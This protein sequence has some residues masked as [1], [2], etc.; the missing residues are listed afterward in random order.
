MK[1]SRRQLLL[2]ASS[3]M[4][5]SGLSACATR[6]DGSMG[7]VV[8][9]GGG[10]GGATAAKHIR[11]WSE[12]RIAVTLIERQTQFISCPMSNLVIGGSKQLDDLSFSYDGLRKLGINVVNA[13]VSSVDVGGKKV[14]LNGGES[15]PYTKLVVSPGVD[16]MV[17]QVAGLTANS[18]IAPHAWKAGPQTVLLRQQLQAMPDGGVAVISIPKAP[19]RC[20]P[21]P[22]ERA[23]QI[24][25]YFKNEKPKSKLI[26][27]DGNEDVVSKKALFMG[28][29]KND[30]SAQ[31]EYR[32]NSLVT[33]FDANART[34]VT[35]LGDKVRA[36]VLNIIPPQ[37]AGHIAQSTGLITANNRWCG[38]NWLTME[39]TVAPHVHV[40]GD[41][42]LSAPLMPK[43]GHMANQ[44]GK[45]AAAAIVEELSGRPSPTDVM[46][47]NT[48]YSYVDDKRVVHVA[49]VHR[50]NPEKKTM[51]VVPGSMGVSKGPNEQEGIY[52]WAWA[53]TMWGNMLSSGV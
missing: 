44:H 26:I 41:A 37:R 7:H 22:Y 52:G 51:E 49:S 29:W 16:F 21:G 43:S 33:E 32:N 40:L 4:V 13:E 14:T 34:V 2:G 11:I 18:T 6:S 46:M 39:S 1:L 5:L 19:Y 20:P 28:V 48:C 9:I 31:V 3:A 38:V 35:E 45:M 15:I 53:Q 12:G 25:H 30:Y 42:T 27:L 8:V 24:A 50:Y 47:A 23:C 36:D 17:D 10:F